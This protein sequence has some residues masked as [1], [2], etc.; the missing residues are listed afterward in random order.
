MAVFGN[1]YFVA[2][3]LLMASSLGAQAPAKPSCDVAEGAKGNAARA[4]LSVNLARETPPGPVASTS[5]KNAVKLVETADK[6]DDPIVRAYV[7]GSALSLWG[8]QPG[9]GLTPKR[10]TV[11]FTTNPEATLDLVGTLD[12]LFRVVETA[13]PNCAEFTSYWRAGQKFYLDVVNGAISALNSEK[14][15]SAEYF[16]TQANRLYANSPYGTM[17][18]GSV[19]SKRGNSAKAVEYWSTAAA[20]AD[21]DTS[22]RD[23]R[24]QMLANL[25]NL[26]LT[27]A[28]NSSG[29]E[30]TANARKAADAFA[31]LIAVPGTRGSFLSGGRQS[32]QTAYLIAGDTASVIKSLDP[33]LSNPAEFEYQDLLNSAV[34]AARSNRPT[35]AAKL[36]E[37]T[38]V[39]NPNNRDALFN[40]SVTYLTLEQ[41][42]KVGPIVTRLVAID[43]GNPENYNLAARAYLAQ[44]KVAEK[45]KKTPIAAAYNDSTLT[46]FNR[47]NKLPVEVLFT[48]FSPSEKQV[49]L[50]GTV[51][52]RRDRSDADT[53]VPAGAKGAKAKAA[54]PTAKTYGPKAFT[55]NFAAL[56]K[57][58]AVVGSQSITTEPLTPGKVAKFAVT[59]PAANV[60]A[61]RYTIVE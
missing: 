26:Y 51:T 23:V 21:K 60:A 12:S 15:D 40:L 5:L 56:D 20:L 16:A 25:G 42:D 34:N 39:Q 4:T 43:P 41:N 7:L 3:A 59:V 32:L 24:R 8:N 50:G 52:D 37:A 58:G 6:S 31:L 33:L 2:S 47:G 45:A 9:V 55:L 19:A 38:L 61:Y 14:L 11:G 54:K 13:K 48:E 57:S 49:V 35:E 27:A 17:V 22:Y 30:K 53:P 44:A 1:R 18:L 28:Q 36:F 29:A 46:W 10:G